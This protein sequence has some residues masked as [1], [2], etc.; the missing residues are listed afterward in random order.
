MLVRSFA[1]FQINN[2][3][4]GVDIAGNTDVISQVRPMSIMLFPRFARPFPA[5][6][7][8]LTQYLGY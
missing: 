3:V 1:V 4:L 6:T 5:D 2:V 8:D 7:P